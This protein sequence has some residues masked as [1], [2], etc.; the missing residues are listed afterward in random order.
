[1]ELNNLF[2]IIFKRAVLQTRIRTDPE[3]IFVARI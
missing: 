2:I 1:M 3:P